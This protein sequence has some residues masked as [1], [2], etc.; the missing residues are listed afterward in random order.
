MQL[1]ADALLQDDEFRLCLPNLSDKDK[2]EK[3]DGREENQ[4]HFAS[5]TMLLLLQN[6]P[7]LGTFCE[8]EKKESEQSMTSRR[9]W[10]SC[11]GTSLPDKLE[12][13]EPMPGVGQVYYAVMLREAND[14]NT[15]E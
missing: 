5:K 4:R 1:P 11:E 2:D 3:F 14:L 10:S 7:M 9:F 13:F 15:E 12:S 6:W 8:S